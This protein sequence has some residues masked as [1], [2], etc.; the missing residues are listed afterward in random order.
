[1]SEFNGSAQMPALTTPVSP[2][3]SSCY[4]GSN[5]LT[6]TFLIDGVVH[7]AVAQ[8]TRCSGGKSE[9]I[10]AAAK[11]AKT[12]WTRHGAER[13]LLNRFHTGPWTGQWLFV[14]RFPDWGTLGKAQ[15]ALS[16]DAEYQNL[17]SHVLSIA[18]L[19]GRNVLDSYDL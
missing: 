8:F 4:Q 13:C 3:A 12:F 10:L 16:K 11:K 9:E 2:H 7:M 5:N 1:M 19:E 6:N 18:K 17:I 15:D 14:A